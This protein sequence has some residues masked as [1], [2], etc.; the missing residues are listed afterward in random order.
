MEQKINT[1]VIR[2][3]AATWRHRRELNVNELRMMLVGLTIVCAA[4]ARTV[5][6]AAK[7][8]GTGMQAVHENSGE[9]PKVA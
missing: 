9:A 3:L 5:P 6:Q 7:D 8:A 2:Q 4:S 1:L